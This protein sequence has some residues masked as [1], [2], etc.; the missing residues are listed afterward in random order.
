[1]LLIDPYPLLRSRTFLTPILIHLQLTKSCFFH[2]SREAS[3]PAEIALEDA[4]G[5]AAP[6]AL[7]PP[8]AGLAAAQLL[9]NLDLPPEG[10]MRMD[11]RQVA[12]L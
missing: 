7:A 12:D 2:R 11:G 4:A 6:A 5:D 9:G 1:V 8:A 10:A 3:P